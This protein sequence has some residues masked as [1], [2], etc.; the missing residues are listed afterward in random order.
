[1]PTPI[2][3][4]GRVYVLSNGGVFDCYDFKTGKEVYRHRILRAGSGFSAS[5][6]ASDV[7]IYLSGEGG[8]VFVCKAG[9]KFEEIAVNDM[10]DLLMATPALSE[11]TLYVRTQ[12]YL[13]AIGGE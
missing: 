12:H 6:I 5:P 1:M 9:R 8:E 10:G 11:G 4:D 3:Y 7:K 2:I 13:Y